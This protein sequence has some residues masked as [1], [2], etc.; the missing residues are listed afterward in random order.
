M[1]WELYPLILSL[2]LESVW[3]HE[4]FSTRYSHVETV[5]TY[6]PY[7]QH[8]VRSFTLQYV[9]NPISAKSYILYVIFLNSPSA[10]EG[11]SSIFLFFTAYFS[12]AAEE[13]LIF[14]SWRNVHISHLKKGLPVSLAAEKRRIFRSWRKAD[15]S[16]LKKGLSFA[17]WIKAYLWQLKKSLSFTVEERLIFHTRILHMLTC[18]LSIKVTFLFNA[19]RPFQRMRKIFLLC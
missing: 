4:S 8:Y 6:S 9:D 12:F 13:R 19:I 7:A 10:G 1:T 17:V 3:T 2:S 16:Q 5:Y 11:V 14:H 18:P 15:L